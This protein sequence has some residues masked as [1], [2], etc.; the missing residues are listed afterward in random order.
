MIAVPWRYKRCVT[1]ILFLFGMLSMI[2]GSPLQESSNSAQRSYGASFHLPG[3]F[4]AACMGLLPTK[5]D[6]LIAGF[7][8]ELRQI[9]F[10]QVLKEISATHQETDSR[11]YS[12]RAR[13]TCRISPY[14]EHMP[15]HGEHR[16]NTPCTVQRVDA[17]ELVSDDFYCIWQHTSSALCWGGLLINGDRGRNKPKNNCFTL[18]R[19]NIVSWASKRDGAVTESLAQTR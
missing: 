4:H 10:L 14:K 5:T 8:R 6:S 9:F 2:R 16:R 12:C 7:P 17:A 13:V 11:S 1:L 15:G 18:Q 3:P 19:V